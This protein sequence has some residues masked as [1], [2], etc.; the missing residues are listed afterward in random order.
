MS[1]KIANID[2]DMRIDYR[3][4]TLGDQQVAETPM[5]QF[6][7]WYAEILPTNVIEANA[8]VV[9]TV[10]ANGAPDA[11][12]VLMKDHGPQGVVFYT[13]YTSRKG[14]ELAVNPHVAVVFYWPSMERQVRM[15]GIAERVSAETSDA[16]FASRPR[17]SQ[18]GAVVSPQSQVVPDR[19]WLDAHYAELEA[20][21]GDG[22]VGR[23]ESWGGYL[24][25]PS[26]VEFWQGR[27]NRMHDRI[28]YEQEPEKG[29][30]T[31]RLA[32]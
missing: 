18:L 25:R 20:S 2:A 16:Y 9:A 27:S 6:A 12:T 10:D 29:W 31:S 26:R 14:Q 15:V 3:R 22:P 13:H 7:R 17:G 21:V 1:D 32:P 28:V 23:P 11:R 5:D 24:I 8:M 19:Q 30:R 4:D